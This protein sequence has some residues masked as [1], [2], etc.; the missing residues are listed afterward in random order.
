MAGNVDVVHAKL[1]LN[2]L[3]DTFNM[4]RL[5]QPLAPHTL[6][7]LPGPA[8][9]TLHVQPGKDPVHADSGVAV[10]LQFGGQ[11]PLKLAMPLLRWLHSAEGQAT[12]TRIWG[13]SPESPKMIKNSRVIN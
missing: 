12:G 11:T 4:G 6:A 13:T 9:H 1:L 5:R 7:R 8:S 2:E 10:Y 3:Q